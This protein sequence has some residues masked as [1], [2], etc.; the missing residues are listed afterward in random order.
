[1]AKKKK[2]FFGLFGK[3]KDESDQDTPPGS[4]DGGELTMAPG[5]APQGG[6]GDMT[7]A[8]GYAGKGEIG[9]VSFGTGRHARPAP[10]GEFD[11]AAAGRTI[12]PDYA[13]DDVGAGELTMAPGYAGAG[14][15]GRGRPPAGKPADPFGDV[16]GDLGAGELTMAPGYAG[17]DLSPPKGA[18]RGAPAADPFGDLGGDLGAGELTMAPGYAGPDLSPPRGAARGA[19][20]ADPFGD[21]G[22]DL[23][24]GE[25][26]MAPGYAGADLSPP[27][28]AARGAPAADPFGDLG[29]S[30]LTMAPG[31]AGAR[32]GPPDP[33]ADLAGERTMAPGYAGAP[34]A[35]PRG[36]VPDPFGDLGGD[37]GAG[38]LTMAPGYAG[39]PPAGPRGGAPD[40]FGDLGGDLGAG[41]L[42]MAPGYAGAKPARGGPVAD[43]FADLSGDLGAGDLTM[44]PGYA[45]AKPARG[46]PARPGDPFVALDAADLGS[47]GA[48]PFAGLGG[49]GAAPPRKPAPA[50]PFGGGAF[51]I[52]L[53]PAPAGGPAIPEDAF[54]FEP[55][56]PGGPPP[57][58]VAPVAAALE[59][60]PFDPFGPALLDDPFGQAN[61][62]PATPIAPVATP[63]A[64][65]VDDEDDFRGERT[66][67]DLT[68][69]VDMLATLAATDELPIEPALEGM[70][71]VGE[72][73]APPP[74]SLPPPPAPLS[75]LLPRPVARA[76]PLFQAARPDA[77]GMRHV[78]AAA[79]VVVDAA[80]GLVFAP[81]VDG[82]WTGV[83]AGFA[84][85]SDGA[86]VGRGRVEGRDVIVATPPAAQAGE[87]RLPPF[88]EGVKVDRVTRA[89]LWPA[90]LEDRLAWRPPEL[91]RTDA[92]LSFTLPPGARFEDDGAVV[93]P[94]AAAAAVA[95]A[96]ERDPAHGAA[97]ARLEYLGLVEVVFE[98]G[99]SRLTLPAG[100]E[101][102]GERLIVPAPARRG[103]VPAL[104]QPERLAGGRLALPFPAGASR[105]GDVV[106]VPPAA[107]APCGL[108][109]PWA[110]RDAAVVET[111][112]YAGVVEEVLDDGWTRLELPEGARV[113][114]GEPARVV[115]PA[116]YAG[117][118]DPAALFELDRLPDGRLAFDLP[119]GAE[120]RRALRRPLAAPV[121][122]RSSRKGARRSRRARRWS[123][124]R[125]PSGPRRRPSR[126]GRRRRST[127]SR[128]RAR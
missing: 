25:L 41:D 102:E 121:S 96:D 62:P 114:P 73:V 104:L 70:L 116:E 64:P 33:F 94:S 108:G 18:A 5:Y 42:T 28:G 82:G 29:A 111:R 50:D 22:G 95:G 118:G 19:P 84:V 9:H 106:W 76:R 124:S 26:T 60:E 37:L 87:V 91:R 10:S 56:A 63:A 68:T 16:G 61:P 14:P 46:G 30:D 11:E 125:R 77:G 15:P 65:A 117:L 6:G 100:A 13:D 4:G 52:E 85:L 123:M 98:D 7:M 67:V 8:P 113:E 23:G 97:R 12:A 55:A 54:S 66:M 127:R 119:A 101:V 74:A 44:A 43:P 1:M 24:A 47:S 21:L 120:Y 69:D 99:W 112:R 110:D 79:E 93:V 57:R 75:P 20:A 122:G 40:P 35:G 72:A 115:L 53:D 49:P 126:R 86:V 3:G 51:D 31:Y 107:A 89:V 36:G 38:D 2:G 105:A 59:G 90:A 58:P 39:A 34:P 45:G 83:P 81:R 71:E 17:A 92:G 48:D 109:E 78:G 103:A 32:G 27:K 128:P 88:P 80:R